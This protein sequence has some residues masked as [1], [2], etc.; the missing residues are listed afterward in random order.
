MIIKTYKDL[1]ALD[2]GKPVDHST[3]S[4]Y[5]W[6]DVM[7]WAKNE[8]QGGSNKQVILESTDPQKPMKIR[9]V[10]ARLHNLPH[11]RLQV[12]NAFQKGVIS[13]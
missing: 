13:I 1:E 8:A 7:Y 5:T 11:A 6:D 4:I 12:F 2:A 9:V 3:V 10:L